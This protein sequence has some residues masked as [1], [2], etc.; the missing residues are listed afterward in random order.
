MN[1]MAV[2]NIDAELVLQQQQ[3]Q[4]H[5]AAGPAAAAEAGGGEA[6]GPGAEVRQRQ[7]RVVSLANG[8][9]CCTLR[10]DLLQARCV[11]GGVCVAGGGGGS[12][13]AC[14]KGAAPGML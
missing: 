9:I 3:Q 12:L 14:G 6:A 4:L 10:G 13:G 1:D 5:A 7:E 2:L 8:C 11:C